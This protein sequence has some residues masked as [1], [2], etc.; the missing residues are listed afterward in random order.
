[1]QT[2]EP[3]ENGF[4][5]EPVCSWLNPTLQ[6]DGILL[7]ETADLESAW[8]LRRYSTEGNAAVSLLQDP[9]ELVLVDGSGT[10]R[11]D[12]SLHVSHAAMG[13]SVP[14]NAVGGEKFFLR[15]SNTESQGILLETTTTSPAPRAFTLL[16]L[17]ADAP[18][19]PEECSSECF[20]EGFFL[21]WALAI[22]L[23][24]T[25]HSVVVD[26]W[27]ENAT[28]PE[29]PFSFLE[30]RIMDSQ[31]LLE[32]SHRLVISPFFEGATPMRIHVSLLDGDTLEPVHAETFLLESPQIPFAPPEEDRIDC[33]DYENFYQD[34]AFQGDCTCAGTQ[35][36][37]LIFSAWIFMWVFVRHRR[38][39]KAPR[40]STA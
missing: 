39:M 3:I 31:Y 13:I 14:T 8:W 21:P 26:A 25:G 36:P 34:E 22:D 16:N 28:E 29:E 6:M 11:S 5:A 37:S 4:W 12:F 33:E 23:S 32:G 9:G 35:T 19:P 24:F 1:M 17:S 38:H 20:E 40:E 7:R 30:Q 27:Y 10:I 15:K 2:D 18:E